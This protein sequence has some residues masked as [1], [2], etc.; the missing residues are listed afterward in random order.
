[1]RATMRRRR[2][3]AAVETAVTMIVLIPI[4]FYALFLEDLLYYHLEWQE[5]I[6][7]SPWEGLAVNFQNGDSASSTAQKYNRVAYCDHTVAYDSFN[8]SFDCDDSNHHKAMTAHQCWMGGGKQITCYGDADQG[9]VDDTYKNKFGKGGLVQCTARLNVSNWFII[10]NFATWGNNYVTAARQKHEDSEDKHAVGYGVTTESG[11]IFGAQGESG[12]AIASDQPGD[13][14]P[15]DE[16]PPSSGSGG[17]A[18]TDDYFAVLHDTWAVFEAGSYQTASHNTGHP[19]YAR[20]KAYYDSGKSK[21]G[22]N[23]A[24]DFGDALKN[25]DLIGD[26]AF[27][28]GQSGDDVTTAEM[29]F[30]AGQANRMSM[31]SPMDYSAGWSDQRQQDTNSGRK[32]GYMGVENQ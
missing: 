30:N 26:D 32:N 14:G 3:Q 29:D 31:G 7:V 13:D 27:S 17:S 8:A 16:A 24:K 6:V 18:N 19:I 9:N 20:M 11:W 21:D 22:T 2:G 28:D 5:G 10:N 25:D 15:T 4:I 12:G 23:A 1:M